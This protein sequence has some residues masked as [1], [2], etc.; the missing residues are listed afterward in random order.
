[1]M[2]PEA[3]KTWH[4]LLARGSQVRRDARAYADAGLP[5]AFRQDG[6]DLA[7]LVSRNLVAAP[8]GWRVT[9]FRD[10]QPI[11][12]FETVNA[13]EAFREVIAMRVS[14]VSRPLREA[15]AINQHKESV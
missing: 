2:A 6:G 15:V 10:G 11:G 5:T 13:Y 4:E 3:Q 1:M 8:S 9:T 12:H 7:Y 14:P